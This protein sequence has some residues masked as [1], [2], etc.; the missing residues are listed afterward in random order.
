[1]TAELAP[2]SKDTSRA[3]AEVTERLKPPLT[4]LAL[5][6]EIGYHLH[7][8]LRIRRPRLPVNT[9]LPL[10]A[11]LAHGGFDP[12]QSDSVTYTIINA[13]EDPQCPP[14]WL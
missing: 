1:M 12:R 8:I 2:E 9:G 5:L 6:R 3:F 7:S 13:V 10:V 4:E 14:G 11:P